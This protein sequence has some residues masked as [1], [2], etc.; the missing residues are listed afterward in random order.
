MK[1]QITKIGKEYKNGLAKHGLNITKRNKIQ[2]PHSWL[3][4]VRAYGLKREREKRSREKEEEVRRKKKKKE[5]FRYGTLFG[6]SFVWKFVL[7]WKF[8]SLELF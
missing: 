5:K 8:G 1:D 2:I 3:I 4:W 7:V 6:T